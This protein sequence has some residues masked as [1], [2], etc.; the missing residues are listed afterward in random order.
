MLCPPHHKY[1]WFR[2]S[3]SFLHIPSLVFV[4][5]SYL[6][7][8]FLMSVSHYESK[9]CQQGVHVSF[10]YVTLWQIINAI[11]IEIF[12]VVVYWGVRYVMVR[13]LVLSIWTEYFHILLYFWEDYEEIYM[14]CWLNRDNVLSW[15]FWEIFEEFSRI[16]W[17]DGTD[18]IKFWGS[19][20][21][22]N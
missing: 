1:L 2:L 16:L 9:K 17:F 14:Q 20:D 18:L 10:I 22:Q 8:I 11:N 3:E 6:C 13:R 15:F 12:F 21:V 5:F 19:F 7:C 4:I